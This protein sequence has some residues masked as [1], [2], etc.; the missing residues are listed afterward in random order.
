M[1][2]SGIGG[3]SIG[4]FRLVHFGVA[5]KYS[6]A[7]YLQGEG[8]DRCVGADDAP[9]QRTQATLIDLLAY[10]ADAAVDAPEPDVEEVCNYLEAARY[11]LGEIRRADGLT[12]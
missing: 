1:R 3:Y 6:F 2:G 9:D 5:R 7:H 4:W 12:R 8:K 10:E 11:A